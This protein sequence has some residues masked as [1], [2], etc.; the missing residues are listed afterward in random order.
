MLAD[1]SSPCGWTLVRGCLGPGVLGV[2]GASRPVGLV[3]KWLTLRWEWFRG[4]PLLGVAVAI[5]GA[6]VCL[7]SALR[8]GRDGSCRGNG[9]CRP[10]RDVGQVAEG[11]REGC[12]RRR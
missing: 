8:V 11:V 10:P 5:R 12:R 2:T 3:M 9:S 6:L 1:I 4:A 7:T